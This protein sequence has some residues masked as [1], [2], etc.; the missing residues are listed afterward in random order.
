MDKLLIPN[1]VYDVLKFITVLIL[2]ISEFITSLATIFGW[3][4]GVTV[5]A[6]LASI[7]AFLGAV[8]KISSDAYANY[9][10]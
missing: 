3:D 10:E 9:H 2:P 1:K 5:V 4:W 7:H 8:I 6:V